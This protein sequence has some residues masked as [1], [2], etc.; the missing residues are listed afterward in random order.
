VKTSVCTSVK[1]LYRKERIKKRK[2]KKRITTEQ[3]EKTTAQSINM[4]HQ[5]CIAEQMNVYRGYSG[6]RV[7]QTH[8]EKCVVL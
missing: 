1:V 3:R 2:E 6:S 8:S 7:V 4:H 5:K